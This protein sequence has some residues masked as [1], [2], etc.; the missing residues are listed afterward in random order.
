VRDHWI[1]G[2]HE[3]N[4]ERLRVLSTLEEENQEKTV[5]VRMKSGV[6]KYIHGVSGSM[7]ITEFLT[8]LPTYDG[9]V[10]DDILSVD[11]APESE[12][13]LDTHRDNTSH[14]AFNNHGKDDIGWRL[15][16]L[17]TVIS[18]PSGRMSGVEE[19]RYDKGVVRQALFDWKVSKDVGSGKLRMN[20][21]HGYNEIK[22][23]RD[24]EIKR[25]QEILDLLN[26]ERG[27]SLRDIDVIDAEI[28]EM[29]RQLNAKKS[30]F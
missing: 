7:S 19:E 22:Q 15:S 17:D 11:F 16:A 3:D 6:D 12:S 4:E 29:K 27:T 2:I 14:F 5:L 8:A 13:E 23:I 25:L 24:C 30:F 9:I 20:T 21:Q 28:N 18:D 10:V 1:F 26:K